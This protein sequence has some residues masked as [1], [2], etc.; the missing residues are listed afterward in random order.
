[1]V[2][3]A[4]YQNGVIKPLSNVELREDERVQIEIIRSLQQETQKTEGKKSE[5]I[6]QTTGLVD[7]QLLLLDEHEHKE[8]EAIIND[9]LTD[10]KL[11]ENSIKLEPDEDGTPWY[12]RLVNVRSLSE[13]LYIVFT[14]QDSVVCVTSIINKETVDKYKEQLA[15]QDTAA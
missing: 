7:R 11:L 15:A 13:D 5:R 2:I 8:L 10:P 3:E 12:M 1:M 9:L 14:V 6:L 4:I